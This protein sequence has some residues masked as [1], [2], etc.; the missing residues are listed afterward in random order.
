MP[1][2]GNVAIVAIEMT[3]NQRTLDTSTTD[4]AAAGA[5]KADLEMRPPRSKRQGGHARCRSVRCNEQKADHLIWR[6]S[7]SDTLSDRRTK[8]IKNLDK[9]SEDVRTFPAEVAGCSWSRSAR[10]GTTGRFYNR[11]R[12]ATLSASTS[13]SNTATSQTKK[14]SFWH[15]SDR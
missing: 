4:L 14:K 7:A 11:P 8:H 3:K 9:A 6:G 12:L 15:G 2:G 10:I 13:A 5:G 1:S